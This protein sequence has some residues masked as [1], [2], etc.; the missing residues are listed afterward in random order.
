[1]KKRSFAHVMQRVYS[2][3][4]NLDEPGGNIIYSPD[5][6]LSRL[7][8]L[9]AA[10]RSNWVKL[11][12]VL[13][14]S[15][16]TVGTIFYYNLLVSTEQDVLSAR[17]KVNALLQ[18][19][20]DI[21]IN[22][23]KAVFDYSKHERSVFTAITGIRSFLSNESINDPALKELLNKLGPP[24]AAAP[25]SAAGKTGNTA[26]AADPSSPIAGLLAVA[27][28][29][30]DLKL[31]ATFQSLMAAL[32]EIEKDLASER[33]NYNDKVNIYTTNMMKFPVNVFAAIFKFE[34][35]PYYEATGEAQK[36]KPI[37]Y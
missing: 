13:V 21:S 30:P 20:N 32:I 2:R 7:Y 24:K 8:P 27:E 26:L 3:K 5:Y 31:S 36:L 10:I 4:Y 9:I 6:H 11:S 14:T 16:L 29:Y 15:F 28:Q 19:R 23:S 34:E 22:L 33:I 18:R 35:K 17:G 37:A 25:E 1:M 12:T